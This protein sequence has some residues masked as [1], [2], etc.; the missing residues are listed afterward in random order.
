MFHKSVPHSVVIPD[1][2]FPVFAMIFL[3]FVG[4]STSESIMV[5]I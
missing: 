5:H 4:E 1:L 2:F 3:S